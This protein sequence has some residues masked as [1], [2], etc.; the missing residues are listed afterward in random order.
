MIEHAAKGISV[1]NRKPKL[2]F[3]GTEMMNMIKQITVNHTSLESPIPVACSAKFHVQETGQLLTKTECL[4]S[5]TRDES[6]E[7]VEK[8]LNGMI[9][10]RKG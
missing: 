10:L 4:D 3:C 7:S 9:V 1:G 5:L 2:K 6:V 8:V